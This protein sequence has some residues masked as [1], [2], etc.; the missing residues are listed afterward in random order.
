MKLALV[1]IKDLKRESDSPLTR[2]VCNYVID[3][4]GDYGDKKHI[5]TDVLYYNCQSGVLY[6]DLEGKPEEEKPKDDDDIVP[7]DEEIQEIMAEITE[8]KTASLTISNA[9]TTSA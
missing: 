3:S 8:E 7:S 4:R 2:R 5:F 6:E 9:G 1:N